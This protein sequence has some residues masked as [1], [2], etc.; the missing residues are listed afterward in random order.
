VIGR[1]HAVR[2]AAVA[3]AAGLAIGA[4]AAAD[5]QTQ[6]DSY[7]SEPW[8]HPPTI[9]FSRSV[10]DPGEGD[11]L[12]DAQNSPQAGPL[13]LDPYG[14]LV[15]FYP[16]N[17]AAA[18]NLEV[19][20]Y[21]GQ[22]VLTYWQ[23][24]VENGIGIG[25]DVILNHAYQ[26]VATVHA[27]NGLQA[28]LHEFQITPSGDALITAYRTVHADLSAVG[29]PRRG[30]LLDSVI[31]E[32][33]IATGQLVWQWHAY[34]HVPIA[35]S[36]H[37]TPS[38]T[39]YDF[40]H[41]NSIQPLPN[42]DLLVSARNTFAIYEIDPRT[43]HIVWTLGGKRSSFRLGRGANFEYQHD[44]QMQPNGTVTLFDDAA[45]GGD[46][47]E[48]D[49]RALVI[50][51]DRRH[52]TATLVRAY[53][54]NPRVLS[55]NQ[56]SVQVLPNGNVFVGW[57]SAPYFTEFGPG[58]HQLFSLHYPLSMESYRGYR[59]QWWGQP[60]TPPSV[61]AAPSGSGTTVWAS[62]DGA[63]DVASWEVLA[64]ATQGNLTPL[65]TFPNSSFE[66]QMYVDSSQP[67]VQVQAL[68]QAGNVL[69]TS[70]T[71]SR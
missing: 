27:A 21:A 28:D 40:F 22:S 34:G 48:A 24:Y 23:G 14:Q 19:Q 68:D 6:T 45:A 5:A 9:S 29:G 11:I 53:T 52:R 33:N 16:L 54:N 36:Y 67:Y 7:R 59:F 17:H 66:A 32:I 49:S 71:V 55:E 8:L 1:R 2:S 58:G 15:W 70:A 26:R 13:I 42:G 12:G 43:G 50:R 31:Q 64:G 51:L 41:I 4:P 20:Q 18:F 57:G 35:D 65:A 60:A 69:G 39:P 44:A 61:A 10:P 47:R 25:V 3:L 56:G 63:T 38:R 62:W 46:R 37:G 30:L